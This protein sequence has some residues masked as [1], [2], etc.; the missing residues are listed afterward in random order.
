ME[1]GKCIICNE[2]KNNLSEE[3]IIPDA[4]GGNIKIKCVCKDCN[5][6]LGS[7]VDSLL[8][9]DPFILFLRNQFHIKDKN[10]CNVDLIKRLS[11]TDEQGKRIAIKKGDGKL[12]PKI[13]TGN[14]P[15]VIIE[16][17]SDNSV[18]IKYSGSDIDSILTKIK[19]TLKSQNISFREKDIKE[20]LLEQVNSNLKVYAMDLKYEGEIDVSKYL[21][22]VIKI[23]YES[24]FYL[25]GNEYLDDGLAIHLR[26]Y[27]YNYF[28][29]DGD[30][31]EISR[32]SAQI[33]SDEFMPTHSV[34]LYPVGRVIMAHICLFNV[35][36]FV[37]TVSKDAGRYATNF[38]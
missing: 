5:S 23:A 34:K 38:I 28:E 9:D 22:C 16:K 3:H 31:N 25:L 12:L 8:T 11:F 21:P 2:F 6:K 18:N 19:R 15:E 20:K 13:Y 27:L 35:F 7:K 33:S 14:K 29:S 17:T 1:N 30:D 10:G 4:I 26:N 32:V 24:S 36:S 37:L